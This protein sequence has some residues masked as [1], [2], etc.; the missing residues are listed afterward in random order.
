GAAGSGSHLSSPPIT[1]RAMIDRRLLLAV[2]LLAGIGAVAFPPAAAARGPGGGSRAAF[3]SH[4]GF[5]PHA[6]F[7][8]H[9]RGAARA[10][11]ARRSAGAAF[12]AGL[13]WWPGFD[14]QGAYYAYVDVPGAGDGSAMSA[15]APQDGAA[16]QRVVI[17]HPGCRTQSQTVPSES[18][19]TS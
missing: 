15:W 9:R 3:A 8:A 16:A 1:K 17:V 5:H 12:S 14:D 6:A 13:P 11:A 19:G 4:P 2:P 10:C 18:G 7:L